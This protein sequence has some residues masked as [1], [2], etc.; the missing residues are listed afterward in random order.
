MNWRSIPVAALLLTTGCT[1]VITQ[2]N[3]NFRTGAMLAETRLTPDQVL[4]HGMRLANTTAPDC[5]LAAQP[6]YMPE[7]R[8]PTGTAD[9]AFVATMNNTVYA[10]NAANGSVK[11][12]RTLAD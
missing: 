6:L 11:W 2:H 3:D 1:S 10:L 9:A 4:G 8:F 12:Q 5:A 7:L